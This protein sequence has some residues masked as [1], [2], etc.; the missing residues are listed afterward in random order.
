MD[1]GYASKCLREA[2]RLLL[3]V[4]GASAF[5]RSSP[6]QRYWRDLETAA[7]HPMVN[8]ELSRE[9]YGR[10]LVGAENQVATLI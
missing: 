1:A 8:T 6:L 9:I 10:A 3:D 5:S 7:R 2:V 4:G